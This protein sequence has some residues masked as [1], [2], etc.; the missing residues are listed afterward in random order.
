MEISESLTDNMFL[1]IRSLGKWFH[2]NIILSWEF[3]WVILDVITS[4]GAEMDKTS[5]ESFSDDIVIDIEVDSLPDRGSIFLEDLV[6]FFSLLSGSGE[7][8]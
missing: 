6:E 4:S 2:G 5:S 1:V 3:G 7:T 8:I